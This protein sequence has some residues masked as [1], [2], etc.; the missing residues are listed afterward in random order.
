MIY[1]LDVLIILLLFLSFGA[2]HTYLASNKTKEIFI[3]HFKELLPFYRLAYNV[4]SIASLVIIYQFA[5]RPDIIIYDLPEP[6]DLIILFPQLIGL[7]G[8]IWTLKYFSS[9]EFLGIGQLL[10]WYR[11]EYDYNDLDEKLTLRIEGSYRYSRHPLYFFS[12]VFLMFRP[13]MDLFYI[14]ALISIILYF[15][16]G[17]FYEEKKLL[18]V[19]GNVYKEYQ[20]KVPR[21]FPVK[22][23][24]P[25]KGSHFIDRRNA[26]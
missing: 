17:S 2:V 22:F 4:I 14:T 11:K 1:V 7:T 6:F 15:Y 13:V 24:N 25:Y 8:F 21:I 19:F 16:I 10:R 18:G 26:V 9:K 5:P 3:Y 20:M 12:I 23:L